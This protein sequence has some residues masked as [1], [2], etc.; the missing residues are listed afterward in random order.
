M[1]EKGDKTVM[2]QSFSGI[3][4]GMQVAFSA[5]RSLTKARPPEAGGVVPDVRESL[6][7][8]FWEERPWSGR[9]SGFKGSWVWR[10]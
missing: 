8:Y 5:G 9:A 4:V 1:D 10:F 3:Q 2:N 6:F 7:I